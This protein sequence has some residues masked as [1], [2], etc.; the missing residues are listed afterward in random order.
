MTQSFYSTAAARRSLVYFVSGKAGAAVLGLAVLLAMLRVAPVDVFG[1]YVA[2]MAATEIFYISSGL[3]LSYF[4]QRY[5]PELRIR[6][7]ADQF[8][9]QLWRV[10]G[11]RAVLGIVFAVLVWGATSYWDSFL[12]VKLPAATAAIFAVSLVFGSVMRYIDELLQALLL[13]GWAQAQSVVRNLIRLLAL[14]YGAAWSNGVDLQFLLGMEV[15]VGLLAVVTG[16]MTFMQYTVRTKSIAVRA[17]EPYQLRGALRQSISFYF[18]QVLAQGY[19]ANAMKLLVTTVVG[20]HGTAVLGFGQS[21]AD[22]LRNYSPAFL[23]GGWVRPIMVSRFVEHRNESALKPLTRLVINLSI[24]GL[25]PFGAVFA[26]FGVE[27]AALF[28]GGKYTEAAPLFA[29]LIGVVCLQAVHAVFGMVCATIERTSFVLLATSV[30]I[31]TLPLAYV[32][33]RSF[34]LSGTVAALFTGEL[35]WLTT[36]CIQLKALLGKADF[37]DVRGLLRACLLA[38]ALG[39]VLGLIHLQ[40]PLDDPAKWLAAAGAGVALYWF[41]TWRGRV[42]SPEQIALIAKLLRRTSTQDR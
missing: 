35:L 3:G 10:L 7:S 38:C 5:V 28:A 16:I 1:A 18:A 2:L 36:V 27:V 6:A 39:L 4:A 26:V 19:G 17:T 32:L 40:W 20:V 11:I 31:A 37:A 24:V 14:A 29:P 34:G 13:Q 25:L 12:G 8:N 42:F 23:L 30:C 21:V 22:I 15:G 33:T 9:G 41:A